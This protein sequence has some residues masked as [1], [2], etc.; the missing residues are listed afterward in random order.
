MIG[1]N[2]AATA[3]LATALWM[4]PA[5]AQFPVEVTLVLA[6]DASASVSYHEFDLQMRGIAAAFRDPAVIAAI[7][8]VGPNGIAV[9]MLQWSGPEDMALAA[10][11]HQIRNAGEADLFATAVDSAGRLPAATGT[12]IGLA[13]RAARDL[14]NNAPFAG[15]RRVIDV[16]GD[17]QA[18]LGTLPSQERDSTVAEGITVNGLAILNEERQ[19]DAYY[20]RNVIGGPGSF[21]V[22]ANTYRDFARAIR[23]KLLREIGSPVS[24]R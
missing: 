8:G 17:G 16:S 9:S 21:V 10:T 4:S 15:V 1:R 24:M 12:A 7:E 19:L 13:I 18:N 14:L 2:T 23:L 11:W 3:A 6:V 22:V 5:E 20:E